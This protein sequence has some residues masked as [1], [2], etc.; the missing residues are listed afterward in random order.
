M[1]LEELTRNE[2]EGTFWNDGDVWCLDWGGG[3]MD[4][5]VCQTPSNQTLKMEAFY[6][7]TLCLNDVDLKYNKDVQERKDHLSL[8]YKSLTW[9]EKW[10]IE[11]HG[12]S[13]CFCR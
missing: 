7:I 11:S 4:V 12:I 6:Y 13:I 9:A 5:Y 10:R 3:Y 1:G 8:T 2:R